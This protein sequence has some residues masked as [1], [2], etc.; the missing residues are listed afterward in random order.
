MTEENPK[1]DPYYIGKITKKDA[2]K[3][4]EAELKGKKHKY[5]L[6]KFQYK[7]QVKGEE[8]LAKGYVPTAVYLT[9][10]RPHNESD[11]PI[12]DPTEIDI[13][14]KTGFDDKELVN[15]VSNNTMYLPN[16]NTSFIV[17]FERKATNLATYKPIAICITDQDPEFDT[18]VH[19]NKYKY[20]PSSTDGN[21]FLTD[22]DH[23]NSVHYK[24]YEPPIDINFGVSGNDVANGGKRTRPRYSR[25]RIKQ[26][27]KKSR[28]RKV[29][30]T[31]R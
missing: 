8:T 9:Y 10:D 31:T 20:T 26:Y 28:V 2:D 23:D 25:K 21:A 16:N 12:T 19:I 11:I 13:T 22:K 6:V 24:Q 17:V 1:Q 30:G 18:M 29:G 5:Y 4:K 14:K 15:L 3:K 7:P 27:R